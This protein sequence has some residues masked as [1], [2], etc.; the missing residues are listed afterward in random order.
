MIDHSQLV[1]R[2]LGCLVTLLAFG[3][4]ASGCGY[5]AVPAAWSQIDRDR[6]VRAPDVPYEPSSALAIAAM[7]RLARLAPSVNRTAVSR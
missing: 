4:A 1:M 5:P 2:R 3:F 6:P 7:L